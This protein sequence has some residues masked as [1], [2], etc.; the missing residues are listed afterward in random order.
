[1]FTTSILIAGGLLYTGKKIYNPSN[2]KRTLGSLYAEQRLYK[3]SA[4]VHSLRA[5]QKTTLEKGKSFF[6]NTRN[7]QLQ[8]ISISSDVDIFIEDEQQLNRY[9]ASSAL[10]MGLAVAGTLF[11]PPL[12]ILSV[13]AIIY[14][15]IDI[16]QIAY[17]SLFKERRLNIY[18]LDS[19]AIIGTL[20]TGYYA[21]S[22]LA[23]LFYGISEKLLLKTKDNS[24]QNLI[25]VFGQQ[26]RFAWLLK[27][28]VELRISFEELRAD[29]IIVVNA[30]EVVPADGVITAGMATIDQQTLTG[31]SQPAEK[32][33]GD[34]VFATTIALIGRVCVKVEKAGTETIA[35]Q[36]SEI[37]NH[38][39]D[40]T[41]AIETQG[42]EIANKS[43]IPTFGIGALAL[44]ILGPVGAVS[45]VS[46][47]FSDVLRVVAPLG[48]L[49]FL[50][51]ASQNSIL[52]KDGRSLEL[53]THVDTF[54][55][56]KTGTLTLEQPQVGQIYP[57]QGIEENQVLIWAAT[58]EYRQTHPIAKAILQ[59]V[60]GRALSL[61]EIEE[62]EYEVGYGIK[63]RFERQV[64]QV[65]SARFM[66]QEGIVIPA[67][68]RD[69]QEY[70]YQHG[71]SLV[72]V[73]VDGQMGGAIELRPTIR[74]EAKQIIN[75]LQKRNLSIYIISGDHER[76]TRKL[77][78]EVGIE[79]Y[80]A[81]T[82]P[83][84]KAKLIEQLQKEGKSVCFVGDGIN[85]SIAM[86]KAQVSIS[87]KGASTV[88]TDTAQIVLM[89][90][91]LNQLIQTFD[92]AKS[93]DANMKNT[94]AATFVPGIVCIGGIFLLHLGILSTVVFYNVS[95]VIGVG[96]AML[97]LINGKSNVSSS[98]NRV[99]TA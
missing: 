66:A 49:N 8:E 75:E 97:P 67:E 55:F 43:V 76:A 64:I 34:Q 11:Y 37:L 72:Y 4:P 57:S 29:D 27:D 96:N 99:N 95:L 18:V 88:A 71:Y 6:D 50:N 3:K 25:N 63:V 21:T 62:A 17:T 83:E 39:A 74:P 73:A 14:A 23:C 42:Q 93:L 84:D 60:A 1:M 31:E 38:T 2:K 16:F 19:V 47:N 82:L 51:L 85:D 35:A 98:K 56:D 58:A 54:V 33:V 26:P 36:I 9:L 91:S 24:R 65:G 61:P 5:K 13:P 53:L 89:D 41:S 15:S 44:S 20:I 48:M 59:E 45:A 87:L 40:F 70:C 7:Q 28:G 77:A 32:G 22:A 94:L 79:R 12:R 52:I 90:Q 78:E 30:G 10:G 86:K 69:K 68:I 80:F 92:L 81:E 46:A